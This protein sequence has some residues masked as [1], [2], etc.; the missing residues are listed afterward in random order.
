VWSLQTDESASVVTLRHL[1]WPGF[2]FTHT[3]GSTAFTRAYFGNGEKNAD[4]NF[5]L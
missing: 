1:E 4:V 2:E 5:M 3:V